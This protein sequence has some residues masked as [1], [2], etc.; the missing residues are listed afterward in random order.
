MVIVLL[1]QESAGKRLFESSPVQWL[2]RRSFSIYLVHVPIMVSIA[3]VLGGQPPLWLL[4]PCVVVSSLVVAAWFYR[5]VER[6]TLHAAHA[7]GSRS[8][9]PHLPT[10][11]E[12][13][14][15]SA[16]SPTG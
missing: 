8:A 11:V 2:G 12:L 3:L 13:R 1:L 5:L 16:T 10:V 6:P 4:T 9:N 7:I 14:V 15:E